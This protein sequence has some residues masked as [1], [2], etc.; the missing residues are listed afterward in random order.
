MLLKTYEEKNLLCNLSVKGATSQ[1]DKR[2]EY[3]FAPIT[4]VAGPQLPDALDSYD[5][6][7]TFYMGVDLL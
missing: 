5:D 4:V 7:N 3:K 2:V 1:A 6:R